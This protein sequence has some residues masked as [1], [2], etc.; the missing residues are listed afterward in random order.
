MTATSPAARSRR[1]EPLGGGGGG[2]GGGAGGGLGPGPEPGPVAPSPPHAGSASSSAR[3]PR[4]APKAPIAGRSAPESGVLT[5]RFVMIQAMN[6]VPPRGVSTPPPAP[7]T[8]L[9]FPL[10]PLRCTRLPKARIAEP[11]R[12]C[13]RAGVPRRVCS[14]LTRSAHK[15]SHRLGRPALEDGAGA[16]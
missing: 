15:C 13:R 2:G 6:I 10:T 7:S 16:A 5:R 3:R 4:R 12:R 1:T 11:S 14:L 8:P 9:P